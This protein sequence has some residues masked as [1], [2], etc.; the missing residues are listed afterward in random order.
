[1]QTQ[2][3][4]LATQVFTPTSP[5]RHTFVER[6]KSTDRRTVEALQ[7]PGMQLVLY[8][9]TGSGK[10][11][12]I[13]NKL[14]Q[15]VPKEPITVRCTSATTF[16]DIVRSAF[17]KLG[18]RYEYETANGS[19]SGKQFEVGAQILGTGGNLKLGGGG[20]GA[21]TS[22]AVAETPVTVEQ[23]AEYLGKA[24]QCLILEDLHKVPQ[25]Q[26]KHVAEAMKL[27]MDVAGDYEDLRMIVLGARET[28]GE[29]L[30]LDSE[31]RNRAAEIAVPPMTLTELKKILRKGERCLNV[32]FQ[33][34]VA[35]RVAEFLL[36]AASRDPL[37]GLKALFRGRRRGEH[38]P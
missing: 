6:D 29:I 25:E 17:A 34:N 14:E 36:P 1:M 23:L 21:T 15:L 2:P 5:A 7:T 32:S 18:A 27:F 12:L 35:N 11:T 10:T 24:G 9:P 19:P 16:A 3:D 22:R 4:L 31:M 20:A 37:P 8:G 13:C 28:A 38:S 30:R 26:T 33:K